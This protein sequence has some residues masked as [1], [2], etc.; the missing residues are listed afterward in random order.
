[1]MVAGPTLGDDFSAVFGSVPNPPTPICT[2]LYL[3]D[4]SVQITVET[5]AVEAPFITSEDCANSGAPEGPLC[6]PGAVL[7]GVTPLNAGLDAAVG[8]RFGIALGSEADDEANY[9]DVAASMTFSAVCTAPGPSDTVCGD[10]AVV[11]LLPSPSAPVPVTW[12]AMQVTPPWTSEGMAVTAPLRYCGA[13][14]YADAG[15]QPDHPANTG[16]E[17]GCTAP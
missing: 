11:A 5:V 3:G 2:L 10:S 7:T 8:C 17:N 14:A 13:T 1:M 6:A 15:G 9:E 12:E 16:A 4:T